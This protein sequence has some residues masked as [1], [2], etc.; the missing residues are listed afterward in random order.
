MERKM[1]WEKRPGGQG[2]GADQGAGELQYEGVLPTQ[3]FVNK[4]GRGLKPRYLIDYLR[5]AIHYLTEFYQ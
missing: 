4:R 1:K 3:D 2:E 5:Y